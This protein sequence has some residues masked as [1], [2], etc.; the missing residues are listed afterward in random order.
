[1]VSR[2][3]LVSALLMASSATGFGAEVIRVN[4]EKAYL[5]VYLG[6][7]DDEGVTILRLVSDESPAA[8]AGLEAGDLIIGFDGTEVSDVSGLV[9]VIRAS[10]PGTKVVVDLLRDGREQAVAVVLGTR[11]NKGQVRILK[12]L[13]DGEDLSFGQGGHGFFFKGGH[14]FPGELSEVF[15]GM[16]FDFEVGSIKIE[17]QCED[18]EGTVS[19]ERDGETE[20]HE[21]D[22]DGDWDSN[23]SMMFNWHGSVEGEE[24]GHAFAMKIPHVFEMDIPNL[25]MEEL[26]VQLRELKEL[27]ALK[28]LHSLH[29]L[30]GM[31]HFSAIGGRKSAST[32]FDIDSDGT[33][34]VTVTKGDAELNLN[35]DDAN[36]LE[37][38]RPDLFEKYEDL[39]SELD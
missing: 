29:G 1:M 12:L 33:I 16:D 24:G 17:V 18:G 10:S 39:I 22:C 36:D 30:K 25:D 34:T 21:F 15:E 2:L 31:R 26:H 4:D 28:G 11:P 14:G 5:G 6:S 19:I 8:I 3:M 32:R 37:R 7:G 13:K 38:S 35:F 27:G 23:K 9:K 20:T